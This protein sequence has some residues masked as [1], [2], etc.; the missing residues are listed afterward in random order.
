MLKVHQTAVSLLVLRERAHHHMDLR[1]H[2][3]TIESKTQ[4]DLLYNDLAN[5]AGA[6][7]FD[8]MACAALVSWP[9]SRCLRAGDEDMTDLSARV[10]F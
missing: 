3:N 2:G 10:T 8:L 9:L 1:N 7:V 6:P 5:C 4:L